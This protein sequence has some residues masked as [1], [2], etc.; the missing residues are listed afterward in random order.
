MKRELLLDVQGLSL[1]AGAFSLQSLS[2]Q[3]HRDDYLVIV[4][5]T[6]SGKTLLLEA[7]AGLVA[8][9][10]GRIFY[11]QQD[12]T[13]APP[14]TRR[15]GFAYQDSLLY[16]HLTVRENILFGA[17]VQG[18]AKAPEIR[19]RLTE[20]AEVLAIGPILNRHP[21]RLSGGERQRV[22]LARALL[23][24]PPLLLLDEPLSAL[25][26]QT[27]AGLQQLLRHIHRDEGVAVIHVTHD[28]AEAMH[29]G[30]NMLLLNEGRLWQ[31]G[32]PQELFARPNSEYAARFLR[33]ENIIPGSI[34]WQDDQRWFGTE[35]STRLFGPLPEQG[36][37]EW[38]VGAPS[39]LAIRASYIRLTREAQTESG[40]ESES[41]PGP[42]SVSAS[43]PA[44]AEGQ[45]KE[46]GWPATVTEITFQ[47][48]YV[49]VT[50]HAGD[51]WLVHVPIAH[52]RSLHLQQ[53]ETVWLACQVSDLHVVPRAG[54][55]TSMDDGLD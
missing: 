31:S 35:R 41:G 47:G 10:A 8:V 17:A 37:S 40:P 2:F 9:E 22:S 14:E 36:A 33:V 27:R 19:R 7:L 25:D 54:Q 52:W 30:T 29:L 45:A 13:A 18:R 42:R 53:G 15:F 16:P 34:R 48:S 26:P 46:C 5:P 49:E 3:V 32:T 6:G 20:L 38:Q 24:Q 1:T 50:C 12:I 44:L 43:V 28:F 55:E 23:L 39:F 21:E 4:G 11:Q 51:C